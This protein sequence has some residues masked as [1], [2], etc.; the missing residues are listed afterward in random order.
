VYRESRLAEKAEA[1]FRTP[2]FWRAGVCFPAARAPSAF[3]SIAH[4]RLKISHEKK[5]FNISET[6]TGRVAES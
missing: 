1:S 2:K 6:S 3:F 5:F 4:F